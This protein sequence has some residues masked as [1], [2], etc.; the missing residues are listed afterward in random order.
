[1][2]TKRSIIFKEV[3]DLTIFPPSRPI[4]AP[5]EKRDCRKYCEYDQD[6]GHITDDCFALKNN[7]EKAI[8]NGLLQQYVEKKEVHLL[9]H[10]CSQENNKI[11]KVINMISGA[12]SSSSFL[13]EAKMMKLL[14]VNDDSP[15]VISLRIDDFLVRRILVDTGSSTNIIYMETLKAMAIPSY[16]IMMENI[17][18]VGFSGSRMY[19]KGIIRLMIT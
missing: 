8:R 10:E 2:N 17:P 6:V 7:I 3:R 4:V 5:K 18:L 15:L 1:M 19:A 13:R 12:S 9:H 14:E 11:P 16:L